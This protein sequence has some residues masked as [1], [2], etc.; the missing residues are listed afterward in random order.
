MAC[1]TTTART[2]WFGVTLLGNFGV[3]MTNEVNALAIT[4]VFSQI[5]ASL[6]W[7]PTYTRDDGA[8][9]TP[10]YQESGVALDS[11]SGTGSVVMDPRIDDL[12]VILP[13]LLG[14]AGVANVYEPSVDGYC[15]Y[16]KCSRGLGI[17]TQ[18]F[19]SCKTS[20]FT[21]SSSKAQPKLRLDWGIEAC[22]QETGAINS[23]AIPAT[24]AFSQEPP[25]VHTS[26]TLTLDGVVDVPMDDVSITGTNNLKTDQFYNSVTR[27]AL[28]SLGQEYSLSCTTPFDTANDL[29]R[30]ALRASSITASI[31]YSVGATRSLT[32]EFPALIAT[33]PT[34]SVASREAPIR[35]ENIQFQA[36]STGSGATL[37]APIKFTVDDTP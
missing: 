30:M 3:D 33:V 2:S 26:S 1:I 15:D 28:P 17:T 32:I 36:Y 10:F 14:N 19:G 6:A 18:S 31:V 34:P 21:L 25:L 12:D 29:A 13:L 35:L 9:G 27:T 11:E 5:S 24:L 16:F 4:S 37:A 23:G 22:L 20:Q 7:T 8:N